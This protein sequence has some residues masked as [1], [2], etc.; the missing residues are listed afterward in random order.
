MSGDI[1]SALSAVAVPST[2]WR[3]TVRAQGMPQPHHFHLGHVA[4][5]LQAAGHKLRRRGAG[6]SGRQ[7]A[8]GKCP[9]SAGGGTR[10]HPLVGF[11]RHGQ[12]LYL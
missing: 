2:L 11:Q 9:A 4:L 12:Q 5:L 8:G 6:S 10:P 1:K 3:R 7:E